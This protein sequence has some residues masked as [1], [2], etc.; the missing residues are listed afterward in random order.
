MPKQIYVFEAELVDFTDIRRKVAIRSSHTLDDLHHTLRAAFAWDD[1]HLYSFWLKG[2]FWARNGSE[3]THPFHAA[4]SNRWPPLPQARR[5]KAP[6]SASVGSSSDGANASP[7]CT[8]SAMS[9]AWP[10]RSGRSAPR[11]AAPIPGCSS[12]WET[13][14]PSTRT[15]TKTRTPRDPAVQRACPDPFVAVA[16]ERQIMGSFRPTIDE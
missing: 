1:E 8:T 6:T 9:D 10:L 15:S 12:R 11:T 5:R 13:R 14:H 7:M 3:Y 2:G 4:Q 16:A